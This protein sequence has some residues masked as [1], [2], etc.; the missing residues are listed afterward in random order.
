MQI[1]FVHNN[2]PA[3]F[4]NLIQV[5]STMRDVRI[6]A[7]GCE[8][9]SSI[10]GVE[11][12]RYRTPVATAD[13][14]PFARRFDHECRR[15]EQVLYAATALANSGFTP[16]VIVVHPGWGENLSLRAVFPKARIIAYCE[17]FYRSEGADV[18]FDPEFP[19]IGLDGH[20]ALQLRNA[21][22]LI[23][24]TDG[25]AGISP[26]LWQRNTFPKDFKS[27]IE[28]I[29]EG[30]DTTMF[31][32]D[33][34]AYFMLPSGKKLTLSDDVLTY[35]A[36][37]LEPMRG[38]HIFMRAVPRVLKAQPQAQILIVGG[39]GVSYGAQPPNAPSWKASLLRE[40][41]EAID[42]QRVHFLGRLPYGDY[43]KVLQISRAHVYLTYP[44][45][46]SWSLLEAMSAGCAVIASDTAPV[47][48][49]INGQNGLL[50][51]FF[52]PEALSEAI[53]NVIG[54]PKRFLAMRKAARETVKAQY[55]SNVCVPKLLDFILGNL[56]SDADLTTGAL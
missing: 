28:V 18:G 21:A 32:P 12:H 30:I 15:A 5:L 52:S 43:L 42:P 24:L 20:V 56:T 45:V 29:H 19:S 34:N 10:H 55:D 49:V 8:T 11:L 17:F 27:K 51:P 22:S 9:A 48:E 16:D 36:R 4:R 46:L 23:A 13:A 50:V 14:H 7:I 39:D 31:K 2:F 44:F 47:R 25:D 38:F 6:A 41:G 37:S 26:T 33:L 1:L 54:E 53:A 40:L 3:Q 35:S